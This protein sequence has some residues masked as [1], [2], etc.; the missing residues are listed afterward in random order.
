MIQSP[1]YSSFVA[2]QYEPGIKFFYR[3]VSELHAVKIG[4]KISFQRMILSTK[5]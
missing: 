2:L 3:A 5:V 4:A 1:F